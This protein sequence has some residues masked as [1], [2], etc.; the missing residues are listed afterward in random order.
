MAMMNFNVFCDTTEVWV[1]QKVLAQYK[2]HAAVWPTDTPG[3]QVRLLVH[4]ATAAEGRHMQ[5]LLDGAQAALRALHFMGYVRVAETDTNNYQLT[6]HGGNPQQGISIVPSKRG[7][8]D[9]QYA[10]DT[11]H[12]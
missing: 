8:E 11:T 2:I 3:T 6:P 1:L 7:Q 4:A 12:D 10:F 5:T 9:D